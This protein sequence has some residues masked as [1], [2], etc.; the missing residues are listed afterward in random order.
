M[1]ELDFSEVKTEPAKPAAVV[2]PPI[3]KMQL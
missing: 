2:R 3:V 1:S